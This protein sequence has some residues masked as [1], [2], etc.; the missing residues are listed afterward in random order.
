MAKVAPPTIPI[1]SNIRLRI[2]TS[3]T[4]TRMIALTGSASNRNIFS[5][6]RATSPVATND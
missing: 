3:I 1:R 6:G 5:A 4:I 2:G